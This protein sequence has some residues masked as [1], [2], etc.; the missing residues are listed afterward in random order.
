MN[1][2]KRIFVRIAAIA[3]I[4]AM[5]MSGGMR[6][7]A[8]QLEGEP[9]LDESEALAKSEEIPE[10]TDISTGV[11]TTVRIASYESLYWEQVYFRFIPEVDGFYVFQSFDVVNTGACVVLYDENMKRIGANYYQGSNDRKGNCRLNWQLEAGKTYYYATW[12]TDCSVKS[13]EVE[14]SRDTEILSIEIV[15]A[16]DF[17]GNN[18]SEKSEWNMEEDRWRVYTL[19]NTVPDKIR[20]K[21]NHGDFE[22]DPYYVCEQ[23]RES[24]GKEFN[25]AVTDDQAFDNQWQIGIHEAIFTLNDYSTDFQFE[26]KQDPIVSIEAS[27]IE[28][29]TLEAEVI[30]SELDNGEIV[31]WNYYNSYYNENLIVTIKT[32]DGKVFTGK[33][34]DVAI[35]LYEAFG[36]YWRRGSVEVENDRQSYENQWELGAHQ[37][38]IKFGKNIAY[39]TVNIVNKEHVLKKYSSYGPYCEFP[40]RIDYWYCRYC[41]KYFADENASQEISLEDTVIPATGHVHTEIRNLLEATVDKEGYTGDTWCLD[42]GQE[43]AKGKVIPKVKPVAVKSISLNK[44]SLTIAAGQSETLKVVFNPSNATNKQVTWS[45][46]NTNLATVDSTGKITAKNSGKLK[47]TATSKDGLKTASCSVRV[48]FSDVTNPK[49]AVYNAVYWGAD[50]G[51]FNGYGSYFDVDGKCTRAQ[52]VL[53]LW[54]AAGKPAAKTSQLKFKDADVIEKMAPDYKKAILWGTEKGIIAGFTSGANAGKFMPNDPCT[55]GQ[56]VTFLW[57]YGGQKA[58]KADAKTFTDVPNTHKYYK[59]I[60]WASSYGIATGFGDGTFRP[61]QTCTRGQCVTFLYRMLK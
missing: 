30:T 8:S 31:E 44:T 4:I 38:G 41:G 6:V 5:V 36:K 14:L 9:H 19:Y 60:M 29:A 13:Y 45:S 49:Q 47:I 42:C 24:F 55:R 32:S 15:S 22:G 35:E 20:I 11:R 50:K 23:L 10:Y 53:F 28:I 59:A 51:Y 43:I 48:L 2:Y 46:S 33:H 25:Y 12:L 52:F 18:C 16:F 1:T 7:P 26:I 56:V 34:Y 17:E 39:F 21:T 58:A 40:G 57:R 37:A 3:L 54:R 61:D 27:D